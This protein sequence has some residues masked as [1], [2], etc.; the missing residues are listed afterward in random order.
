MSGQRI[1]LQSVKRAKTA[2]ICNFDTFLAVLRPKYGWIQL[3]LDLKYLP[4]Y[5]V[6]DFWVEFGIWTIFD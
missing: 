1:G 6:S 5:I 2:K 4:P 3:D